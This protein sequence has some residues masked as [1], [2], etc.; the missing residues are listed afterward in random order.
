MKLVLK[1]VLYFCGMEK[2]NAFDLSN[3][4]ICPRDC[5]VNRFTTTGFCKIGVAPLVSSVFTHKGEEPAISGQNGICNVFF[6]HCNLQCIFCQNHQISK[7]NKLS[8]NWLT[9]V[10]EVVDEIVRVLDSGVNMLGFVSPSHQVAQMV[11]IVNTLNQMGYKPVVVYNSNGYDKVETLKKLEGIVDVYLPDFK[12]FSNTLAF[13]YSGISN[14]FKIAS[15]A[16]KE[17]Y[18]QKG[19][20]LIVNNE[21]LAEFG[22]IV[23]HLVL[24]GHA[25]DSIKILQFLAEEISPKLHISLMSQ[26]Y[27][28]QGLNVPPELNCHVTNEEYRKISE[29]LDGYGFR[30]WMQAAESNQFYCPNFDDLIPFKD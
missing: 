23:R 21:G 13:K 30:G 8:H 19:S 14:Y 2:L 17:M 3:C 20:T 12:Y 22:M 24:P 11:E 25:S 16:I 6:A 15:M 18:R 27:P 4:K 5:G 26:Y 1:H 9:S 10:Q 29:I 28:P 7:N